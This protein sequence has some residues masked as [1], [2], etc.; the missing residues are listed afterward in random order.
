MRNRV[1]AG[2]VAAASA[3]MI[4]F[5]AASQP[6]AN[7]PDVVLDYKLAQPVPV[8]C[9]ADVYMSAYHEVSMA[10]YEASLEPD[11]YVPEAYYTLTNDMELAETMFYDELELVAVVCMAEAEGESELGKRLV[12][13]TVFNRLESDKWPN[14][15]E[16]VIMQNNQYESMWNG[17]SDM[18]VPTDDIFDLVWDEYLQRTNSQ[19]IYFCATDYNG[20]T[21]LFKEGNHYFS[22]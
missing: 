7:T 14:T 3:A 2:I 20:P 9:E 1:Q 16:E 4:I 5:T 22:K 12:I 8:L 21:H 18:V 19:V 6:Q 17:R 13:D 15:I 10:Q 11:I